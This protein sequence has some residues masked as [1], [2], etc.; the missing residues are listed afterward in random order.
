[1][2]KITLKFFQDLS[3]V[4]VNEEILRKRRKKETI[5]VLISWGNVDVYVRSGS[6]IIC[7]YGGGSTSLGDQ[8]RFFVTVYQPR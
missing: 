3:H 5:F 7:I 8:R 4:A 6:N 2:K 1:M